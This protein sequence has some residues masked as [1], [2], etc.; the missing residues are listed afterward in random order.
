M[1][2]KKESPVPLSLPRN[3]LTCCILISVWMFSILFCI[4]FLRCWQ[5]EFVEQS[6]ASLVGDHFISCHELNEWFR[7]DIISNKQQQN[8]NHCSFLPLFC[9]R[10]T[11]PVWDGHLMA[12]C[13]CYFRDCCLIDYADA[14]CLRSSVVIEWV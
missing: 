4:H 7:G 9:R 2:E 6:R 8:K 13:N 11:H 1:K 3:L 5:G 10:C 12:S 14:H